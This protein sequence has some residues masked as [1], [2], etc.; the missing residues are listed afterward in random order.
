MQNIKREYISVQFLKRSREK[1]FSVRV[2]DGDDCL[3]EN[4]KV[5]TKKGQFTINS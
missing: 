5:V 1:T 4:I 2:G 3:Q